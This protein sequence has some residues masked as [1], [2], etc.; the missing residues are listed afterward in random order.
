MRVYDK[1]GWDLAHQGGASVEDVTRRQRPG[2]DALVDGG[3]G[4]GDAAAA[5]PGDRPGRP[6]RRAQVQD[7]SLQERDLLRHRLG[8]ALHHRSL[9]L[10]APPRAL[11]GREEPGQAGRG[12]AQR[13]LLHVAGHHAGHGRRHL[14]PLAVPGDARSHD[15][16]D[17]HHGGGHRGP[18]GSARDGLHPA[19]R[20]GGVE[21]GAVLLAL[22]RAGVAAEPLRRGHP[23]AALLRGQRHPDRLHAV[24]A[25]RRHRAGDPGRAR[26]CRRSPRACSASC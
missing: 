2:Q 10:A 11:Q 17:Q 8:H 19:G 12:A 13:R 5:H 4:A 24:P 15:Q 26:W 25:G 1:E 22:Q 20:Q 16:A 6:G 23:E 14:R 9:H 3:Q 21:E 18:Q 7:G